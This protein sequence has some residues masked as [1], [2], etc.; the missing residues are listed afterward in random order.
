M[1]LGGWEVR[2]EEKRQVRGP[3]AMKSLGFILSAIRN[4]QRV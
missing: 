3:Q 1:W 2:L 4:L